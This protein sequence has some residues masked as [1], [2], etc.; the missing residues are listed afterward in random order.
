MK[1][2]YNFLLISNFVVLSLS[3]SLCLN[4]AVHLLGS[5]FVSECAA[6]EFASFQHRLHRE[7]GVQCPLR[8][9]A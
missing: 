1:N 6:L 7:K 3:L 8:Q 5:P 2:L 4:L 9:Q